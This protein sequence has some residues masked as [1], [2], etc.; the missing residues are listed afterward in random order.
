MALGIV[1][2]I[3]PTKTED[4]L[5]NTMGYFWLGSGFALM[6]NPHT[7]KT[8]G[9]PMS[10]GIGLVAVLTGLLV[11]TRDITRRWV[12]EI[13]VIELLGAA[14]LITGVAHMFEQFKLGQV[15]KRREETLDFMLGIFEIVLG[16]VLISSPLEYGPATYW[17][18]TVWALLFGNM[19]IANGFAQRAAQ[20]EKAE[21]PTQPDRPESVTAANEGEQ[22]D[23]Q[24]N[25]QEVTMTIR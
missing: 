16:L 1:L 10:R 13:A 15:L 22:V 2:I 8:M 12:P 7:E 23:N 6:R 4:M 21:V 5:V 25:E 14:I 20:Q 11:V 9:K 18:A 3:Y 19:I 17:I 24:D